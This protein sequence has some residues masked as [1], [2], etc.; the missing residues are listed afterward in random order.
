MHE[1]I[2][3]M[4]TA[5]VLG[6]LFW[7][8]FIYLPVICFSIILGIILLQII[9]FE[10][11]KLFNLHK[12]S[13]WLIMPLYPILPFVLLIILNQQEAYRPLLFVLFVLVSSH[14]TGSYIAGNLFGRHKI[15]PQVSPRKTWEGFIGGWLFATGGLAWMLWELNSLI[16]WWQLILFSTVICS[17]SLAGDLFESL[18]KRRAHVKDSGSILPGHGGFLDRF[19]GILFTAF[20]FF[21]FKDQLIKLFN[22]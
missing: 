14:D 9:F 6:S 21:L 12:L 16:P 15:L 2:V 10:W 5:L 3:R 7:L 4:I 22:L 17:L 13:F 1:I 8:A 11:T 19:D 18:L 20:F